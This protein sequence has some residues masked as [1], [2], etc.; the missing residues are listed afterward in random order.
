[1]IR[2]PWRCDATRVQQHLFW[3][4]PVETCCFPEASALIWP[5]FPSGTS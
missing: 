2:E 3:Q 1:V 4:S 5:S